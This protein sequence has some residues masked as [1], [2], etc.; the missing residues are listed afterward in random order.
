MVHK[1]IIGFFNITIL[2]SVYTYR[3][4]SCKH[5]VLKCAYIL[6]GEVDDNIALHTGTPLQTA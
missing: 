4:F 1:Y 5:K 3:L 2:S 6:D